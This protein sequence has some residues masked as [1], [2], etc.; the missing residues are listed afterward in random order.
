MILASMEALAIF[1]QLVR[2]HVE[3]LRQIGDDNAWRGGELVWHKAQIAQR[4]ELEGKPE[5]V[6]IAP[7]A[8]HSTPV[9]LRQYEVVGH[10]A[11][12]NI[13]RESTVSLPLA[14]G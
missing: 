3:L 7:L 10:V 11:R 8:V 4:A 2:T 9:G 14:L 13:K 1:G 6:V 5:P 12:R